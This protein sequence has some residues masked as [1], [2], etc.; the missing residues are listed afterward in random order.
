M[1]KENHSYLDFFT[2]T[3]RKI[4][5]LS[6]AGVPPEEIKKVLPS[7]V[8]L[9]SILAF[10]GLIDGVLPCPSHDPIIATFRK[11]ASDG[12]N[13]QELA[14]LFGVPIN[15]IS[16]YARDNKIKLVRKPQSNIIPPPPKKEFFSFLAQGVTYRQ[17]AKKYKVSRTTI[18]N[19]RR[20]FEIEEKEE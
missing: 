15:C 16:K 20:M 1:T 7:Y 14:D 19:W 5:E 12:Y 3:G 9:S 2:K 18:M 17:L 8:P 4:L 6:I 13:S 10:L 11:Y